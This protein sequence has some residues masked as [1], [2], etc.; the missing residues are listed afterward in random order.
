MRSEK[1]LGGGVSKIRKRDGRIVDFDPGKIARAIQKA[2]EATGEKDGE[3]ARVLAEEVVGLIEDRI[4]GIPRVED[5]QDLVEEV[6]IKHGYAKTAKAYIL[7]RQKRAELRE[8][9]EFFGVVDDLKL[10]INAIKVLER[11]YL[12]RDENF[13]IVETPSG[14]F[15]RV[16]RAIAAVDRR[17]RPEREVARAREEFY[18]VMASLEFLPNSPTLMNAGT[19]VG[20]LSACFVLPIEDSVESIFNTLKYMALIHQSGGGTGFSF[21]RIRPKG[22]VVKSTMGVA[23]GPLSF[24][25][26]FDMATEIIKQGGKRRGANMGILRVDHPDILEFIPAKGEEGLL[27]NFNVSVAV[28]DAFMEAVRKDEEYPLVNPRNGKVVKRLQA[29]DVFDLIVVSAWRTGDPG[30]IFIDEINRHNPTPHLGEIES[31]NPCLAAGTRITTDRGL[32]KIEDL[33]ASIREGETLDVF[34]DARARGW[35]GRTLMLGT[36]L[37]RLQGAWFSGIRETVKITTRMGYEVVCTPDHRFLTSDGRWVA[38]AELRGRRIL[39]QSGGSCHGAPKATP[40]SGGR[41]NPGV[42][43][44]KDLGRVLGWLTGRGW[45]SEEPGEPVAA[46]VFGEEDAEYLETVSSIIESWDL[47]RVERSPGPGGE[48]R[49]TCRSRAL[50]QFFKTLGCN[51][52]SPDRRVPAGLF[53]APRE[54]VDGFLE[55]LFSARGSCSAGPEEGPFIRLASA[56]K[57]L[58]RDLQT[59][60]LGM[61][62]IRA[63]LLD[64]LDPGRGLRWEL[65]ICG[66][67]LE[68]LLEVADIGGRFPGLRE[69][70][71][72]T[73]PGGCE[74]EDEVVLVEPNG[75][76]PV[77][78]LA[79]EVSNSFLANGL[80]VHNCAEQPLLPYESCNLGSINLAKMIARGSGGAEIDYG[81]LGRTVRTAIHFL[82]NVIDAN[83]FPL[84]Q[85]ERITKGNRKIGLGVMGFAYALLELGIPYDSP[86]A[87][88]KAEEIMGFISRTAREASMD[89]AGERGVFPN[90]EGSVWEERGIEVRNASVT[91]IAPTGTLSIIA[92]TSSGIEPIFAVSFYRSVMEG[93]RLLEVNPVFERIAR[94]R[95]FYSR[96]LLRRIARVGSIQ[97][98]REVPEDVRRVFVTALEVSP[99]MHVKMQAAFQRHVD[100]AVSKT[101]NLPNNASLRDVRKIFMLAHELK[102]KGITIYRYG[103]KPRQVLYIGPVSEAA[104]EVAGGVCPPVTSGEECPL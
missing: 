47:G 88:K 14:M 4:E 8:V 61:Y 89:L 52:D 35:G 13:N 28:T 30:L 54:A 69:A 15:R 19:P 3:E 73:T 66:W 95:G 45:L 94:E 26:A 99:E 9:K 104:G 92:G 5:V 76:M 40:M 34:I 65:R 48:R 68:R 7:Y 86:E 27:T 77:Y 55:Y 43:W 20:Q 84:R 103:S 46:F 1:T 41:G 42:E 21:S 11:R 49:L 62:G 51:A 17:Y 87:L 101:V 18:R 58:L 81:K 90:Y 70:L 23:S 96:E 57:G 39:L 24:M 33:V 80:V 72:A 63:A 12:L 60:L 2:F 32:V 53:T 6:L 50:V 75:E 64:G 22:D 74:L 91:T 56:S 78:D 102:C 10:G 37:G 67:S 93:T 59:I 31:T 100:S 85:I 82:D 36:L 71:S 44:S 98:M 79:E 29:R 97:G 16:A 38:A 25:R 83:K